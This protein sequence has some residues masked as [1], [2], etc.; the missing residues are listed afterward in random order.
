VKRTGYV[1]GV[2]S[3][4]AGEDP[5]NSKHILMWDFDNV[6]PV[7]VV[8]DLSSL[9][10][11]FDLSDIYILDTGKEHSDGKR[12]L[13]AYCFQQ[14]TWKQAFHRVEAAQYV[15]PTYLKM[16]YVRGYFTLR[17][18]QKNGRDFQLFTL[19]PGRNK[20]SDRS[21]EDVGSF[22]RYRTKIT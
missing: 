6:T 13:H 17:F 9:Q 19:L 10:V 4:I 1:N 7:D 14:M 5:V 21:P 2:N 8:I 11:A 22:V 3:H 12:N 20:E 15:D 16:A 18:S